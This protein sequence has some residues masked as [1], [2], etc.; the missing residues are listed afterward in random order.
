MTKTAPV[1]NYF[2]K[3]DRKLKGLVQRAHFVANPLPPLVC[4]TLDRDDVLLAK[5]QLRDSSRWIDTSIE[6]RFADQFAKWNGSK[7]AFAFL[8]GRAALSA[9]I[10]AL[11]LLPGDEVIVPGYTC[12]VVPNAFEF[13]Q[14]NVIYSD[15][16]L[17]TYG[18]DVASLDKHI[19]PRTKAILIQHLFG[20]V[21]RDY[22]EII[23]FAKKHNLYVIE[24]CAHSTG[25]TFKGKKVGNLIFKI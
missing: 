25:A 1:Q 12:V 23:R 16:E 13:A 11:G 4:G 2:V 14:V 15:I 19:T 10:F 5:Q 20:L 9:C 17:E 24:D 21:C 6:T 22:E 18:L 3:V 8:S 7:Y